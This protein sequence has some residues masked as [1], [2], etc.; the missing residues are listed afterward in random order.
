MMS[1]AGL[2]FA[3]PV[4][5][6]STWQLGQHGEDRGERQRDQR[7]VEAPDAQSR[8]ADEEADGKPERR[9]DRQGQEERPAVVDAEPRRDVRAEPEEE[10]LADRDLAAVADDDHQPEDRDGVGGDTGEVQDLVVLEPDRR[11]RR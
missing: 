11:S 9:R 3:P 10:A 4:M 2:P 5:L 7:E 6:S 1:S 8:D